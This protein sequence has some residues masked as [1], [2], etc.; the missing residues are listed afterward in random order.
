MR[1]MKDDPPMCPLLTCAAGKARPCARERCEWWVES[2][3]ARYSRCAV[4][5]LS[6]SASQLV[7][8]AKRASRDASGGGGQR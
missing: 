2:F 7:V 4:L 3:D 8:M 1:G 6:A 5:G